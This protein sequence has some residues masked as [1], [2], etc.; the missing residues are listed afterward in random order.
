MFVERLW[1]SIKYETVY[2]HAY[3]P[4]SHAR[5]GIARYI[6]FYKVRCPHSSLEKMSADEF[7]VATLP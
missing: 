7:Y 2:Q 4:V 6:E 1:R 3:D 5:A